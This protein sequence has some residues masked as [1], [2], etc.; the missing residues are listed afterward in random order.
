M[1][2]SIT[3]KHGD[4]NQGEVVMTAMRGRAI[5]ILMAMTTSV[6]GEDGEGV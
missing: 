3:V 1:G 6:T 5:D 2:R 4:A